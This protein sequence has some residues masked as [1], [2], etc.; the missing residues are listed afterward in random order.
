M[1]SWINKIYLFEKS[2][3]KREGKRGDKEGTLVL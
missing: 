2:L 1:I 3:F